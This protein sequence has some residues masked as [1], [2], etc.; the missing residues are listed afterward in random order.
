MYSELVRRRHAVVAG[1]RGC[2]ATVA[3]QLLNSLTCRAFIYYFFIIE[4]EKLKNLSR[5]TEQTTLCPS[6]RVVTSLPLPLPSQ[7]VDSRNYLVGGSRYRQ[8]STQ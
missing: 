4:M 8:R 7:N 2:V 5:F 3:G 1:S 6:P